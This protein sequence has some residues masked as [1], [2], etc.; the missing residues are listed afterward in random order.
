MALIAVENL[1]FTYPGGKA[2]AVK[3]VSFAVQRGEMVALCGLTGSG[4]STTM[5]AMI[6]DLNRR[7]VNLVTLEDPDTGERVRWLC[8]NVDLIQTVLDE[9]PDWI[10]SQLT[11][12][13]VGDDNVLTLVGDADDDP[14]TLF[15]GERIPE[16]VYFMCETKLVLAEGVDLTVNELALFRYWDTEHTDN[17]LLELKA[18]ASI[19]VTGETFI[20]GNISYDPSADL[21]FRGADLTTRY[22]H[23]EADWLREW[24]SDEEGPLWG[25]SE[26]PQSEIWTS[27]LDEPC[28]IFFAEYF[29]EDEWHHEPVIPEI[30]GVELWDISHRAARGEYNDWA[31]VQ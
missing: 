7:E 24:D 6:G 9:H 19:T 13:A 4:K 1:S 15:L 21:D 27:A 5:N 29:D 16:S 20:R 3:D 18:N 14:T 12:G 23:L 8:G 30:R 28:L 10:V 31:F 17:V 22:P 2:P 25:E 26:D 11:V